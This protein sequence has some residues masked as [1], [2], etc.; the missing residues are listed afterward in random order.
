MSSTG[1]YEHFLTQ[2]IELTKADKIQ[3]NYLDSN[4]DLYNQLYTFQSGGS[5]SLISNLFSKKNFDAD[6]SF[7]TKI[8]TNFIVV[9]TRPKSEDESLIERLNLYLVPRTYKS[10]QSIDDYEEI[11]RLQTIIR[12]KFPNPE[13]IINDVMRIAIE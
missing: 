13:D 7:Y 11:V 4:K 10:I 3:W 12:S 2:L 8:D 5:D 9:F 6:N 1:I